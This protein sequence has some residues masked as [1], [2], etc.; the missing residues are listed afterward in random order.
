MS[1]ES[2]LAAVRAAADTA[3][4]AV[5]VSAESVEKI[6]VPAEPATAA[7]AAGETAPAANSTANERL[8]AKKIIGSEAAVG[9]EALAQYF[10]FD[11]D[12]S[13]E[14]AIAALEKAPKA[15]AKQA[16]RLDRAMEGYRPQVDTVESGGETSSRVAGLNAAVTRELKKIGK[17]PKQP[18]N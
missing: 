18:L 13:A 6:A 17:S 11:T 2:G 7:A 1:K 16:S 5:R 12:M 10:A 3:S 4:T 8:R 14:Q 9:R 15:E